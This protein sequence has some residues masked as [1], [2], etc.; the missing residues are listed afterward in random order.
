M[1]EEKGILYT[2]PKI[3]VKVPLRFCNECLYQQHSAAKDPCL[4]CMTN[5]KGEQ[6]RPMKQS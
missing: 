1:K 4:Q 2:E 5:T 3:E 6:W